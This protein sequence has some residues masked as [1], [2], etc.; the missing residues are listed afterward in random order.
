MFPEAVI[1]HRAEHELA[2]GSAARALA[3]AQTDAAARPQ[4]PN[5]VL[6]ARALLSAGRA[7]AALAALD[8]ADAQGWVGAGQ[9]MARSEVLAALGDSAGS[10][11]ARARAEALNPRAADPRT[12]LIWFG[13]D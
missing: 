4:A 2:V 8:R 6:L 5:L 1:H 7:R 10:E 12:R 11:A 9:A 3:Y 13:H